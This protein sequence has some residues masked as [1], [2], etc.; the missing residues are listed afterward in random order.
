MILSMFLICLTCLQE[1]RL[2]TR[3]CRQKILWAGLVL[4]QSL[5]Q[6]SP[7]GQTGYW[8]W[9]ALHNEVNG[10]LLTASLNVKM[11]ESTFLHKPRFLCTGR[12]SL[13]RPRS[14]RPAA[15][16]ENLLWHITV[17]GKFMQFQIWFCQ[18]SLSTLEQTN[19][20]SFR[21]KG[22]EPIILIKVS[23]YEVARV[24][25]I[26]LFTFLG[27]SPKAIYS[28]CRRRTVPKH[29]YTHPE[30]GHLFSQIT[31]LVPEES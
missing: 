23:L 26:L 15:R 27:S 1:V 12:S 16:C 21:W 6:P 9:I 24:R 20:F 18:W 30:L 22:D 29:M 31:V 17:W 14:L 13:L 25:A 5:V 11:S 4:S 28:K 7:M 3:G 19:G 8:R 10:L 2:P